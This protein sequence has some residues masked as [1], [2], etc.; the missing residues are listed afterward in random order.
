MYLDVVLKGYVSII[1]GAQVG[2]GVWQSSLD[3][4][5]IGCPFF[6][7]WLQSFYFFVIPGWPISLP[8][9]QLL[10]FN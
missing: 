1:P 7:V 4:Y 8:L 6:I 5:S 10:L 3:L 2:K 9:L